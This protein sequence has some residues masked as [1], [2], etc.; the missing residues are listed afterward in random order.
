M[1]V[2]ELFPTLKKV[3]CSEES[4]AVAKERCHHLYVNSQRHIAVSRSLGT[5]LGYD[6]TDPAYLEGLGFQDRS[7]SP[8]P[9]GIRKPS[10][11]LKME[12]VR[13]EN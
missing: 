6:Q 7:L 11:H 1:T 12:E 9:P 5:V 8:D 4:L 3:R 13:T 10:V 2:P